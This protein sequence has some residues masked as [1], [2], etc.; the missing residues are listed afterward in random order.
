[1]ALDCG[2]VLRFVDAIAVAS[3]AIPLELGGRGLV[4]R[5]RHLARPMLQQCDRLVIDCEIV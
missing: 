3:M 1:M 5:H 4:L 2:R